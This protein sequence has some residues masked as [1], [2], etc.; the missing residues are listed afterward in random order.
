[1]SHE[2]AHVGTE[3]R[4][5]RHCCRAAEA[6]QALR[7]ACG[8]ADAARGGGREHR[9]RADLLFGGMSAVSSGTTRTATASRMPASR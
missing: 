6:R 1:M 5:R 7:G 8:R 2:A 3:E 4:R 9:R